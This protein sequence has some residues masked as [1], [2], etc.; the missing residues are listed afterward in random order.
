MSQAQ[1]I[2]LGM[3]P[4]NVACYARTL[5]ML[6]SLIIEHRK[7]SGCDHD[8]WIVSEIMRLEL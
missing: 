5:S 7:Y 8:T 2:H 6:M 4:K 3:Q 1:S